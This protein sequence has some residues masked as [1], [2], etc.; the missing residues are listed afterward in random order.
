MTFRV[1]LRMEL[2]PGAGADFE[3]AWRAGADTI[4]GQP[5]NLGQWLCRDAEEPDVYHIVSDWTDESSFRTY[6]LSEAHL[7]HRVT[8]HPYRLRGSMSTATVLAG[9]AGAG[10]GS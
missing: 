9:L 8:L 5:A 1:M 4:T 10:A 3:Q 6:E 2:V 7:A